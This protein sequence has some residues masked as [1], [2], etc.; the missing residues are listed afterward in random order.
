MNEELGGKFLDELFDND[1]KAIRAFMTRVETISRGKSSSLSDV[2]DLLNSLRWNTKLPKMITEQAG[3]AFD[4]L[5]GCLNEIGHPAAITQQDIFAPKKGPDNVY[6]L[7]V[8]TWH[9]VIVTLLNYGKDFDATPPWFMPLARIA[10]QLK[11]EMNDISETE[12]D[13]FVNRDMHVMDEVWKTHGLTVEEVA[14]WVGR[15][16]LNGHHRMQ[17]NTFWH[18]HFHLNDF[19]KA[20]SDNMVEKQGYS[21]DTKRGQ[22]QAEECYSD[23]KHVILQYEL[24]DIEEL[25]DQCHQGIAKQSPGRKGKKLSDEFDRVRGALP[26][27]MYETIVY[28][29]KEPMELK[30]SRDRDFKKPWVDGGDHRTSRNAFIRKAATVDADILRKHG[31]QESE[32]EYMQNTGKIAYNAN[33]EQY[34]LTVEHVN[35]REYG[36]TNTVD[37]MILLHGDINKMIDRLKKIQLASWPKGQKEGWMYTW[38]PIE[39]E[40]GSLPL[41]LDEPIV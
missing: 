31:M 2:V 40:D 34:P 12:L 37:N 4:V 18:I 14:G 9:L 21:L 15:F 5:N 7:Y 19:L 36:G 22:E 1:T 41:V 27:S 16:M 8:V 10:E 29:S 23:L 13:A 33:G 6:D 38:K 28:Y 35:D 20:I 24:P 30:R 26:A 17:P 39:N 25:I 11:N 3:G 32:I